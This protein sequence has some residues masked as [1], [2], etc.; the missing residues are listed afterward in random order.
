MFN[1]NKYPKTLLLSAAIGAASMGISFQV[2]A[3]QYS[4]A[5]KKWIDEAFKNSTLSKEEQ[6]KELEWF[7]KAAEPFRGMEINVVSETI[8]THEYE[9]K[10]LAEAFTE[11]TGIELTHTLIQEGDVIEKLQTQMQ[12]GRNIYDGWVN[13]SDLIGTHFRY[14]KV[15]PVEDIMNGEGKDLTLPTLDL[16]DFIGLDF[17]TGPDGKLYQLPDQQFANLYWFRADWFEREDLK[18]QF[19]DIYGYELGVPV[20]WSA[21]EDIAEFFSVHV[22]EIDGKRVYGHMDYGK[23]DPSLGWRFTDAWFSMAGAGDKGLP[24]GL[25]VDEWGIRVNECHPVGASVSR[26]GATNGPAAVYATTKYVDWLDKYAPPEA[27]GMTFSEAGPVPAQGNVAQQIFWYT[28]FTASMI[29]DGLPVVNEDGTPKWRMAPSPRGP[30][31]EEGMKLGYQDVGSWTF[32]KSTPK[33]RRLAAWL[34]AQFTVSKT[35]SLEKTIAGLTPIRESDI[36]SD[37]MTEMAPKLGGLVE[38]YRS[39]ARVQWS[40]TGTNVPDYPKLAQLW[41]QYIAQAASG[42]A[43]PQK[44]LDGLAEAQD[45]VMERLERANVMPN[46]GPKL[47]E[48]RDPQYWLDQPGAPKPKLDNEKPQG[49]TVRYDELLKTWEEARES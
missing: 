48:P 19:Q 49:K 21:Y 47:N 18:K 33:E 2:S 17:T 15:M 24:N 27:Q 25:P 30:Y 14:G 44:A 22:K 40:P 45:R 29:E 9:S 3:D 31:W 4:D 7:I 1:N 13:D 37:V 36:N 46:C 23:K 34:Y 41:W 32:M 28:A 26:G 16:E 20:N 39:P 42:E 8:A 43:T 35:V 5:A 12:S 6:M 38:F 11:I 10:V